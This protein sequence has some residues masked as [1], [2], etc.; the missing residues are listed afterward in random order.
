MKTFSTSLAEIFSL[1]EF[2]GEN[3]P[4]NLA[5]LS[6]YIGEGLVT[7]RAVDIPDVEFDLRHFS[8]FSGGGAHQ[9]YCARAAKW[10][11][12]IGKTWSAR[13]LDYAGGVADVMATDRGIA[14]ECGYTQSGKVIDALANGM[15]VLV[16]PYASDG[17]GFLFKAKRKKE[18]QRRTIKKDWSVVIDRRLFP[19]VPYT[20]RLGK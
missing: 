3:N 11:E 7:I 13:D 15:Q 5:D 20:R 14:V 16:F 17:V 6:D 1:N 4:K 12:S 2:Y 10:L 8:Q 9:E 19:R 18:L